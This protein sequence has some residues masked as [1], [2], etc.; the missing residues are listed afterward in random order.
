MAG[1]RRGRAA[2]VA[3]ALLV[4]GSTFWWIAY[5]GEAVK[6][7]EARVIAGD[8]P[9]VRLETG[10]K[11]EVD[12]FGRVAVNGLLTTPPLSVGSQRLIPRGTYQAALVANDGVPA[13][14]KK[15]E[16]VIAVQDAAGRWY[17][18]TAPQVIARLRG[19]RPQVPR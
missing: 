1:R 7:H 15:T 10:K 6:V 13:H 12:E 2:L 18:D 19:P 4:V 14:V 9:A 11:L 5:S 8:F 3:G 17:P 16:L